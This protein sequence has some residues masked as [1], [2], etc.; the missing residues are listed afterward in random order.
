MVHSLEGEQLKYNIINLRL[1][2]FKDKK[3]KALY[4]YLTILAVELNPKLLRANS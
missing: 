1:M 4:G 2:M 3:H